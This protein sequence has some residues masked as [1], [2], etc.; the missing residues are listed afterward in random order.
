MKTK[1]SYPPS[2]NNQRQV[3]D[4]VAHLLGLSPQDCTTELKIT[5][6]WN[7]E[8]YITS[9]DWHIAYPGGKCILPP[10][11]SPQY[12]MF[13]PLTSGYIIKEG[14]HEERQQSAFGLSSSDKVIFSHGDYP[15][16]E[17]KTGE[18]IEIPFSENSSVIFSD[19][20]VLVE[21]LGS[22]RIFTI[23]NGSDTIYARFIKGVL[24][25]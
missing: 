12:P 7:G 24:T 2:Y 15:R 4:C 10:S 21:T 14:G 8:K 25:K 11:A 18:P 16:F 9:T 1:N 6:G 22:S 20:E 5:I 3:I 19:C 17:F 23:Q 13:I